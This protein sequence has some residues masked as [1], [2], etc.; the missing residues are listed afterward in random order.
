MSKAAY[1]VPLHNRILRPILRPIFRG[2]FHIL[3]RVIITGRDNV[4]PKGPYLI[5]INHISIYEPPFVIAFWPTCPE[6]AGAVEIWERKGQD[7]LARLYGG[8]KV[9]RGEYD[10]KLIET[11]LNVLRSG[12]PLLIAPE[13]GRT[14]TPGMRRG[15]PGVAYLADESQAPIVPVGI[16]GSTD[17]FLSKALRGQRPT[18]EMHI[19]KPF[20]L[21]PIKGKGVTR[22]QMRQH[23]VDLIMLQIAALLPPE[24]RGVYANPEDYALEI[25]QEPDA[26]EPQKTSD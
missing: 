13:G 21:P 23:H 12:Y 24:Y 22:R 11:L 14:H 1:T 18:I 3:S 7:I 8:I 26:E 5:T 19:G 25:E 6:A 20:R 15:L 16:V 17:D 9:H 4:P 10:R 2:L